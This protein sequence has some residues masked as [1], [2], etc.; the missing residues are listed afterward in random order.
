MLKHTWRKL[1][2]S[3][4]TEVLRTPNFTGPSY[5]SKSCDMYGFMKVTV[6]A[7]GC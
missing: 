2:L 1:D 5:N 7:I 3:L 4:A 6:H